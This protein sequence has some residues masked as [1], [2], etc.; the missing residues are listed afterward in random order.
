M[1]PGVKT[2][3][4]WV[5][6][7][8]QIIGIL[9]TTGMLDPDQSGVL[10]DA[11]IKLGGL[12][13]VVGSAFGYSISRGSAKKGQGGW[14]LLPVMLAISVAV[15]AACSL[16]AV[17]TSV[18]D[19]RVTKAD[20]LICATCARYNTTPEAINGVLL[21][22]TA[23]ATIAKPEIAPVVCEYLAKI[24]TVYDGVAGGDRTWIDLLTAHD[25]ILM[26]M[27]NYQRMT[28]IGLVQRRVPLD[29]YRIPVLI[30]P[31]DDKLLRKGW[32]DQW[33]QLGC[34]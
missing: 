19:E 24:R 26:G 7:G 12:V 30:S 25:T 15:I 18:C 29:E 20:S 1:K 3:E 16:Y 6:I 32:S 34:Q 2:T 22:G 11:I 33:N 5:T 28:L 27:N 23:I 17:K 8:C 10:T 14:I 9:A 4:F 31:T 13:A 21:D